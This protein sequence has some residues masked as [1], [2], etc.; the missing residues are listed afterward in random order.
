MK[1][2]TTVRRRRRSEKLI[3]LAADDGVSAPGNGGGGI[4]RSPPGA[5]PAANRTPSFSPYPEVRTLAIFPLFL[6]LERGISPQSH[7]SLLC[8]WEHERTRE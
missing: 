8:G 1:E 4:D 2:T 6:Q 7:S 3:Y 5:K